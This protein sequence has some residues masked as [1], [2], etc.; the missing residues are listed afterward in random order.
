M[1]LF[2]VSAEVLGRLG[3]EESVDLARRIILEDALETGLPVAGFSM[4]SNTSAPD[5]GVDGIFRGAG[6][7]SVHGTIKTGTTCYQV[8][9]GRHPMTKENACKLL[10]AGGSLKDGIRSCI[11][12]GGTFVVI[13]TQEDP[14]EKVVEEFLA[15]V[16]SMLEGVSPKYKGARAEVWGQST[17]TN[18]LGGFPMIRA[19]LLGVE[20]KMPLDYDKWLRLSDGGPRKL[21]LGGAQD[22][23]IGRIRDELSVD[24]PVNLRVVGTP[25]IGK[26]SL[27]MEAVGHEDF[28]GRV[29]YYQN[30]EDARGSAFR[31]HAMDS[32]F[33]CILVVDECTRYEVGELW[34][35]VMA[36]GPQIKL[37]TIYNEPDEHPD[38]TMID[39]PGLGSAQMVDI[40]RTYTNKLSV[41]DMDEALGR[42]AKFCGTSPRVAH[43]VGANLESN[44][45]DVIRQPDSVP[46]WERC[47]AARSEIGTDIYKNRL[48]VMMWLSLFKRIGYGGVYKRERDVIAGLVEKYTGM[49]PTTFRETVK[50]LMDMKILQGR[51]TLYITPMLLHVYFWK[52]WWDTYD[53]SDMSDV[54]DAVGAGS[55]SLFGSYCEMFAY[56]RQLKAADPLI[57]RLLGPG[58]FF[59]KHGA[60]KT[61]LGADFFLILSRADRRSALACLE[62][63]LGGIPEGGLSEFRAG[64]R[65]VVR[66]L[67]EA[68][69]SR[70]LF[71]RS[72]SLLLDLAGSENEPYSNNATGA[73]CGLFV[74]GSGRD[75]CT[76]VP[77]MDRIPSLRRALE[78]D[79]ARKQEVGAEA[80]RRALSKFHI[81]VFGDD[82]YPF[83]KNPRLWTAKS[84]GEII[85][86]YAAVL[87]MLAEF[88]DRRSVAGAAL[89][90]IWH[91]AFVDGLGQ[92]VAS[93]ARALHSGGGATGEELLEKITWVLES[94][95]GRLDP[96]TLDLFRGLQDEITGTGYPAMM[97]RYVGM[98]VMLD[99]TAD[100]GADPRKDEVAR[101]AAESLEPGKLEPELGWL[102]T[103]EAKHGKAFGYELAS[104]DAGYGLLPA[105]LEAAR[106]AGE[107]A[108]GL[109]LGG[110]MRRMFEEDRPA[111][112]DALGL[113]GSDPCLCRLLPEAVYRSGTTDESA[114]MITGGVRDG[115]IRPHDLGMFAYGGVING[116]SEHI[117]TEWAGLLADSDEPLCTPA[118]LML[119]YMYFVRGGRAI[120][121][122]VSLRLLLHENLA[123]GG[124][125]LST[126]VLYHN[127]LAVGRDL[128]ARHPGD[129]GLLARWIVGCIGRGGLADYAGKRPG[130]LDAV[131]EARPSDAWDAV[132]RHLADGDARSRRLQEWL[133]GWRDSGGRPLSLMP[134]G[135]VFAWVDADRP[136]R[137]AILAG[138][139]P[140]DF[141]IARRILARYWDVDGVQSRISSSFGTEGWS[142]SARSHYAEK[143]ARFAGLRDAEP[144]PRVRSW[145]ESYVRR[146]DAHA[147]I[148]ADLE[149]R[150]L[151][152]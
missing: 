56:V 45:D 131:A 144:D 53:E 29:A 80:C 23:F 31:Q 84:D 36:A 100:P 38:G 152:P 149:E 83:E 114:M 148:H 2:E 134:L 43:I 98:G 118:G 32:K 121:R 24:Q 35:F 4:S 129:S 44:A 6:R 64:R 127:W 70:D 67:E 143:R 7:D 19:S 141:V 57:R 15:H 12:A 61:R 51:N 99:W 41:P 40:L 18:I 8:K 90:T 97:R 60:L 119:L 113:I 140:P 27:V 150:E 111:W 52:K 137:A 109:F 22:E 146:I 74:P 112:R 17:I 115:R 142:G 135:D 69:A 130:L 123:G 76:E 120:P 136:A 11:D 110:Y 71:E 62:R 42:W 50:T 73:F 72:A 132:S 65:G 3:P 88:P 63:F 107:R 133:R 48:R 20:E 125:D 37:V 93:L 81:R 106:G 78:S 25:G 102:V 104:R 151:A 9:S 139:C 58:G 145:L 13:L 28:R 1:A 10:F 54:L 82:M 138:S 55:E 95:S 122:D 101:L 92:S 77:P 14:T 116:L 117:V 147:G 124:P 85:S 39:V 87:D 26:T 79:S 86:Y 59:D 96:G 46:V 34:D 94:G 33:P 75:A 105:I 47:I 30:P 108:S 68:A 5:G 49:D 128:L 21:F 66:A 91:A 126:P 103:G 89:D 16:A